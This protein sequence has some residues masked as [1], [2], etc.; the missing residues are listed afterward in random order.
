MLGEKTSIWQKLVGG[1]MVARP[2]MGRS[3]EDGDCWTV[4]KYLGRVEMQG[5][6][7]VHVALV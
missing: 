7:R 6:G 1:E 4:E 2:G 5:E 3:G